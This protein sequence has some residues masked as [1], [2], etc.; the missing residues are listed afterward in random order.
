MRH[1][2]AVGLAVVT[3]SCLAVLLSAVL[4]YLLFG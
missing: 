2:W 4:L 1:G 3:M